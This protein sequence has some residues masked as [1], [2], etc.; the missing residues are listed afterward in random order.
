MIIYQQKMIWIKYDKL[1]KFSNKWYILV[2][3][4][5]KRYTMYLPNKI[6]NILSKITKSYTVKYTNGK[7]ESVFIN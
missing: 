7:I 3:I 2:K 6:T 1:V 5:Y 4:K